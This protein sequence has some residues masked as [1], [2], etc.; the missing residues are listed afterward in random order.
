MPRTVDPP[1]H[2][3]G[4]G[5]GGPPPLSRPPTNEARLRLGSAYVRLWTAGTISNLGDGI[6]QV[7]LP[8]LAA[9]LTRDPRLVAGLAVAGGLPWLLFAL[10][11]GALVDRAD[12]AR[13][14]VQVNLVRGALVTV[15]AVTAATGTVQIWSLYVVAFALGIAETLFDNAAQS[16]M[17]A[18]VPP[19]LLERANG[20]QYA[21]E[22]VANSFAG[23][24]IGGLLFALAVS[25][26]F[27]ADAT[28]FV[29]SAA[30]IATIAHLVPRPARPTGPASERRSIRAEIAEGLRWLYHHRVLRTLALLLGTLNLCGNMALATFVLFAQEEL[31]LGDSGFGL[32]LAGM[33][34]GGVL[35]GLVGSRVAAA[36][37]SS[38]S[39]LLSILLNGV[40]AIAIGFLS[41]AWAV[42]AVALAEG[43]FNVVWNVITVSLRQRIIPSHLFGRV[44]SAYRFIGWG[45]SPIGALAGGL[46]ASAFGLRAP[47]FIAGA[48]TLCALVPAAMVL[49]P[50][51]LAAA[52]ADR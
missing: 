15:I 37:G 8:L 20:R 13:L 19:S 2:C 34:A 32:L 1:P 25:L 24:P 42:A 6:D 47:F 28:S 10:V 38:R 7:A 30:L 51:A 33:A 46:L 39:L 48:I 45:A 5:P 31:G 16:I 4:S 36:F 22:V 29:A 23:P 43:T 49:T 14:M 41:N 11:A 9:S 12:R 18:V 3:G 26:P 50:A 35:G 27:W 17:P 44:N 21:A 52:E 40:C